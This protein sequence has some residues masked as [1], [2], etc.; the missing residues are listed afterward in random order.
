MSL[1]LISHH[2]QATAQRAAGVRLALERGGVR[3]GGLAL[4]L[5]RVKRY[6]DDKRAEDAD[7]MERCAKS[8]RLSRARDCPAGWIAR[9]IAICELMSVK[10]SWPR[11]RY[12]ARHCSGVSHS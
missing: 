6:R 8:M 12:V 4:R 3:P 11:R 1:C 7:T 5:A 10:E 9:R 2:G